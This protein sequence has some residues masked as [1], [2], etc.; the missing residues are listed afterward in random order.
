MKKVIILLLAVMPFIVFA[1]PS[2]VISKIAPIGNPISCGSAEYKVSIRNISAENITLNSF[3]FD[4]DARLIPAPNIV[5]LSTF[6][7][8]IASSG[9]TPSDPTHQRITITLLNSSGSPLIIPTGVTLD[10]VGYFSV[11]KWSL[12]N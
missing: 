9:A 8:T 5:F 12:F 2:V 1:V 11:G 6:G 4:Y 7:G 10:K 3:T